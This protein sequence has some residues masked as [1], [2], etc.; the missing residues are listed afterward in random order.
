MKRTQRRLTLVA[1]A[2]CALFMLGPTTAPAAASTQEEKAIVLTS[3]GVVFV[4]TSVDVSV[5]LTVTSTRTATGL[6]AF[7]GQYSTGYATGSGF[8]VNPSGVVVTAGHVVQPDEQ[9]I[10]NYAANKLVLEG[11]DYTYDGSPFDQYTITDNR[12]YNQMLQ[13]CYSGVACTFEITPLVTVYTAKDIAGSQE[14][15]GMEARVLAATTF[16]DTDVAVL[17][18]NG[19]NMPT[20]PLAKTAGGLQS[21]QEITALGFAGSAQ[22]LPTGVTEPAKIFGHISNIRPVG[23]SKLIEIDANLE[24]GTSGG[25]VIDA[26]GNVIGLVSFTIPT[27]RGESGQQYLRTVDD[28]RAAL[29]DAG[30]TVTRGTVDA[31]F[32]EG[33]DYLWGSHY[34]ASIPELQRVLALSDGQPQAKKYL[35]EAEEK[36]G[37]AADVPL[38]KPGGGFPI[39]LV[40]VIIV[41]VV[42]LVLVVVLVMRRGKKPTAVAPAAPVGV[43][44]GPGVS[45]DEAAS[46]GGPVE[47]GFQPPAHSELPAAHASADAEPPGMASGERQPHF[48]SHCGHTLEQSAQFCSSCGKPV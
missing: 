10:H 9:E 27:D 17:Q 7:D 19:T 3:P 39:W 43:P 48:C 1:A 44:A 42:V 14:P 26:D 11:L 18:V 38:P 47:V 23:S 4:E 28:I 31:A 25:P 41:V 35:A 30:A 13:Q 21:G 29:S 36:Q 15:T 33:M 8:V 40:V 22:Q 45:S 46:G 20:V 2:V 5:R 32:K 6:K 34:T 24:P 12:Y 37:T 16:E